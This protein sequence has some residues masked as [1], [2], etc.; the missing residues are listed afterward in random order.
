M[1]LN[2]VNI[3]NGVNTDVGKTF[4][5]CKIISQKKVK[6]KQINA[7]KPIKTSQIFTPFIS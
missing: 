6:G 4:I 7:I 3:I 5:T 2:E 1:L